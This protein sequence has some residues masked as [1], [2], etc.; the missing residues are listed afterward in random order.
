M[1]V[2]AGSDTG[3]WFC[4]GVVFWPLSFGRVVGVWGTDRTLRTT[5]WTRASTKICARAGFPFAEDCSGDVFVVSH[6]GGL[7]GWLVCVSLILM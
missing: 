3:G 5:Q 4:S 7:S 6:T 2:A 1:G